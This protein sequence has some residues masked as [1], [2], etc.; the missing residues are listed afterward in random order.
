MDRYLLHKLYYL[1]GVKHIEFSLSNE[2]TQHLEEEKQEQNDG[3]DSSNEQQS[4]PA[5]GTTSD[6]TD[7]G[8]VSEK[9]GENKQPQSSKPI[10]RLEVSNIGPMY[11]SRPVVGGSRNANR[12]PMRNNQSQVDGKPRDQ[13]VDIEKLMKI[14][15]YLVKTSGLEHST[16]I[17]RLLIGHPLFFENICYRFDIK[18]TETVATNDSANDPNQ[19]D[20][21]NENV[22]QQDTAS[23]AAE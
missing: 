14:G 23:N 11:N 3:A 2:D 9:G 20:L 1:S 13:K 18:K 8:S 4:Q 12:P 5:N 15:H 6:K 21:I 22:T 17:L 19:G 16:L 10:P 7:N